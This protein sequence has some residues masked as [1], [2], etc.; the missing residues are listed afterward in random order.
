M[1]IIAIEDAWGG[2]ALTKKGDIVFF[3]KHFKAEKINGRSNILDAFVAKDRLFAL[4]EDGLLDWDLGFILKN[5]FFT[6]GKQSSLDR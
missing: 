1:K 6:T 4:A 5:G 2:C 3:N